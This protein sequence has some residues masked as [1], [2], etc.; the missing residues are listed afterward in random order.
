MVS[1][2]TEWS[3][4]RFRLPP[5]APD[6]GPFTGRGFLETIWNLDPTGDLRLLES[7]SA[8]VP[9]VSGRNGWEW[10]GHPDL[11]DYRSPLGEGAAC[12]ISEVMAASSPG[13]S[14]RFD[15]LP[16]EAAEVVRRGLVEAGL[17]SS[18]SQHTTTA[19]LMLPATFDE[20]LRAIGKK[21]RHELRRK[22]RRFA[23][24]RGT[25]RVTTE[26]EAGAGLQAFALM[27]RS[28]RG[29]KGRFMTPR[30]FEWFADL[31][32]QDGWRI[33]LLSGEDGIPA[34]ATFGWADGEAFYLYNSAYDR[35]APG[36]PGIVLLAMLIE[37]AI[38]AGLKVFDFLKGDEPYKYRL[39]AA[40]RPL[41]E[42]QG[43]T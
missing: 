14:F 32:D 18:P 29:A 3:T 21:E 38:T 40:R 30:M 12:L 28:S 11:V 42:L 33:D 39:G 19:R 7:D 5:V 2:P 13:R 20:Y 26:R 15:S 35:E 9:L 10:V 22:T 34:A 31:A 4:P 27:H 25:P 1:S 24:E 37:Q 23:E 41:F 36:S 43:S 8:L 17:E 16:A 6:T